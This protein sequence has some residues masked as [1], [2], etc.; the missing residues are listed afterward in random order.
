MRLNLGKIC[1]K[2]FATFIFSTL[3]FYPF[4]Q[5]WW[6]GRMPSLGYYKEP[7]DVPIYMIV[8]SV[9]VEKPVVIWT[10][11]YNSCPYLFDDP[12]FEITEEN[13]E[14]IIRDSIS[15]LYDIHDRMPLYSYAWS[16]SELR[17]DCY[18]KEYHR[19][20]WKHTEVNGMKVDI[21][22]HPILCKR[23]L[24]NA[25]YFMACSHTHVDYITKPKN[26]EPS[27]YYFEIDCISPLNTYFKALSDVDQ[28]TDSV[29]FVN[30]SK[31][32]NTLNNPSYPPSVRAQSG[33]K[34]PLYF[35]KSKKD[36][37]GNWLHEPDTTIMYSGAT[38]RPMT[39][40]EKSKLKRNQKR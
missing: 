7:Y 35:Y 13:V 10:K 5:S 28:I 3:C 9:I 32:Y 17:D 36:E 27:D 11:G 37:N 16:N 18:K 31:R 20:E 19:T 29:D 22:E 39:E 12:D 6:A 2:I 4:A 38:Q 1:I 21:S 8:D 14:R 40:K 25:A 23:A 15:Y 33:P 34:E 26:G 24:V 30:L